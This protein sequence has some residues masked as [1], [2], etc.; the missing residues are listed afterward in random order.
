[1]KPGSPD[2]LERL[3]HDLVSAVAADGG[4]GLYLDDGEGM[5]QLVAHTQAR[6]QAVPGR[7]RR[8]RPVPD[9][10]RTLLVA[11]PDVRG[12]VLVL[13]R[14]GRAEFTNDDH[15]VARLYARQLAQ[16]VT[17]DGVRPPSSIWTRQL[18]AIQNIAA[19]LTRLTTPE[20]V[21]TAICLET[22]RLIDYDNARV[23]V[24]AEDGVTLDPVAFRSVNPAYAGETAEGLRIRIGDGVTG[25]VAAH[26]EPLIV[27]D[28][29]RDPRILG[30]VRP[31]GRG[32]G[33]HAPG[34]P[35]PR[36]PGHRRDRAVPIG[37]RPLRP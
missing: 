21:A 6:S 12:G 5:L 32:R 37:R 4:A 13:E 36:G 22:G 26:G 30:R 33:I 27:P 9:R 18:E 3:L 25:W 28:A 24:V 20:A 15:A 34:P 31:P 17:V 2:Q 29:S 7:W 10:G 1:M 19:Q 35:A 23:Y 8:T 11:V 16:R 14:E